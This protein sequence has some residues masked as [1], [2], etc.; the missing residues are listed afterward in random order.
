MKTGV[1]WALALV[2]L[3]LA[4]SPDIHAKAALKASQTL[5]ATH[6]CNLG[7]LKL[8]ELV[9][10]RSKG[11]ITIEVLDGAPFEGSRGLV[12]HLQMG[13]LDIVVVGTASLYSLTSDF[14]IFDLPFAIPDVVAGRAVTDSRFGQERLDNVLW[15][16]LKGLAYYENGLRHISNSKRPVRAPSDLQGL[17]MRT[18]ESRIHVETFRT[19]GAIPVPL[20]YT[21]LY[22]RLKHGSLDAEENPTSVFLTGRL[23]EAQKFFSLTG[24]FYLPSPM[25]ISAGVWSRLSPEDQ[26]II[27]DAARE[28]AE[29][30][31]GLSDAYMEPGALDGVAS[32]V[33]VI[34]DVDKGIWRHASAQIRR[35]FAPEVG[36]KALH[37]I[38]E[39]LKATGH[40]WPKSMHAG[41]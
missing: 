33:E 6:P 28:S 32:Q 39:V 29:Y 3:F 37:D 8:K 21:D 1:F 15:A 13:D 38:S 12:E 35:R 22:S 14:M 18:M 4:A 26:G 11:G 31:R 16:G 5:S 27:Q 36:E 20:A 25:F 23:Y 2:F 10:A 19:F 30:Q 9:E 17:R 7:L 24:H 41:K 34:S 40:E